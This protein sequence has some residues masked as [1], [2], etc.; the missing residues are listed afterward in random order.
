MLKARSKRIYIIMKSLEL[1]EANKFRSDSWNINSVNTTLC[2]ILIRNYMVVPISIL[3]Y[4]FYNQ[5]DFIY[6]FYLK[7]HLVLNAYAELKEVG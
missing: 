1:D 6:A 5:F 2:W 4:Y 7:M 3:E